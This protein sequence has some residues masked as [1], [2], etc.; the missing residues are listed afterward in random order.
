MTETVKDL[1]QQSQ[2]Q[3]S[4]LAAKSLQSIT[5]EIQ[6]IG[7]SSSSIQS[8]ISNHR[9]PTHRQPPHYQMLRR[10]LINS[11]HKCKI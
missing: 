7:S 6:S 11:H 9:M 2:K 4:K 3:T 8:Y 1:A 10:I 5:G